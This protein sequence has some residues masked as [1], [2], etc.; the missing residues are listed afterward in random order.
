MIATPRVLRKRI[1]VPEDLGRAAGAI[2][3]YVQGGQAAEAGLAGYYSPDQALGQARG[4]LAEL[5]GL[6]GQVS[7]EALGRLLQ[8]RH[9]VT[10][11]PLLTGP[12]PAARAR[13]AGLV[14]NKSE[15]SSD[16]PGRESAAGS[17]HGD[18]LLTL[19]EAAAVAGVSVSHLRSLVSRGSEADAAPDRSDRTGGTAARQTPFRA[20]HERPADDSDPWTSEMHEEA[21]GEARSPGNDQPSGIRGADGRWRVRRDVLER[22]CAARVPRATVLGYDVVCAA[23]KSVSLLW[24]FGDEALRADVAAA[25]NAA[26]DATIGYLERHAAFGMVGGRNQRAF[27]LA[28]ASYLHDVS[29]A[30]EAHLHVHNIVINALAVPS[31][32]AGP[33]GERQGPNAGRVV[34]GWD[35]RAVDGE[36]LLAHVRT[37]G[38]VGAAVLRHELSARRGLQ[39]GPVRNGVAELADFP[40]DLLAAFSTRH[41]EVEEEFAQLVAGGLE[42]SGAT[43]SVA[44]RE[45]R[46]PKRVVADAAVRALQ[47]E[48]L[49]AAGWS[50][51]EVRALA[52]PGFH[53]P[54]PV[55]DADVAGLFDL[56]AGPTGMTEKT[57]A[58]VRRD[59]VRRVSEWGGDRLDAAAVE[60]LTDRFLADPRVVVLV[61]AAPGQRRR[62][63]PEPIYTV[64]GLLAAEERLSGLVRAGQVAFGAA[65]RRLVDRRTLTAHLAAVG[66]TAARG[67]GRG[68]ASV[69]GAPVRA[70]TPGFQGA[71]AHGDAEP[72]LS[73][74]QVALVRRLLVG[75]DL[76]R[77]AVG[78]AGTGKTE[79]MRLLTRIVRATGRQIFATAHGGRQAEELAERIGI[80]AR[81]VASWLEKLAHVDDPATVWPPGSVLIVDEATQVGTRDAERLLHFASRTGTVVILLGDPAQLGSVAA[82]G[83]FAH[84]V[85]QTADVPTLTTVRRQ[86]GA[87]LTAVR[88]A[89][90]ALRADT[91]AGT[92]VALERLAADGKIRLVDDP[93]ALLAQAVADW[94]TERRQHSRAVRAD[95]GAAGNANSADLAAAASR[96]GAVGA[97][98]GGATPMPGHGAPRSGRRG[99]ASGPAA[100][101]MMAE[102]H[103]D[104]EMLNQAARALLAADGTLTGPVLTVAGRDFQAADEVVTLTQ[105][106]HTLVPDGRPGS[107]YIR[108][109]TTGTVTA[110][111]NDPDHPAA[112]SV[113]VYFPSKGTV[114]VPWEYLTHQFA[115]GRDGGLAHA[116][117]LTAAKAQGA[118]MDTARAI[119]PD[120]TSRA[121]L[122][123]MLSRARSDVA[124]YV[125][126]RDDLD[127]RDDDET[128]LPAEPSATGDPLDRLADRLDRSEQ[129]RPAGARD[130][131]AAAAHQLSRHHAL[132]ELTALRL[133]ALPGHGQDGPESAATGMGEVSGASGARNAPS[134]T[135]P[136]AP[137]AP[138]APMRAAP[139]P[140]SA[141]DAPT[142][143]GPATAAGPAD[144]PRQVLLRRAELGAEAALR[145]AAL[146]D[147]PA[148][149]VARIGPR[150]EAGPDQAVWDDAVAALTIY[151]ARH[152]PTAPAHLAGPPPGS[153]AD[154][155]ARD[156]WLRHRAQATRLADDWAAALPAAIRARFAGPGQAVP[157][158]RAIAGLHALL[159]AGHPPT[160]LADALRA[161]SLDGIRAGA[162]VLERRVSDLC[163]Q[164]GIDPSLYDLPAP[165]T[166]QEEWNE[167]T[168][169]L[170]L[171]ETN[172]LATRPTMDLTAERHTL[173]HALAA[174]VSVP[175]TITSDGVAVFAPDSPA[176]ERFE[177]TA[178]LARLDA[179]LDRQAVDAMARAKTEPA[180]YL[181]AL[182]G[183][184]P[185]GPD[186]E[187]W[188]Q[189]ASR[190]E[191]YRHRLA[192]LPYGAPAAPHA[193]D[194]ARYAL[195][196]RPA[197]ST[198]A[199]DYDEACDVASLRDGQLTI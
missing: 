109:G 104:V 92:R 57:T 23:P 116:Y 101:R 87:D 39:W 34:T 170:A 157:R 74:E 122:Y 24:A 29:R 107:A 61:D 115:D 198:A 67:P 181:T 15:A 144:V 69:E 184:R 42:P 16:S 158:A 177:Q 153:H 51:D 80:P 113:T 146:A 128:W 38:F 130:P 8:G 189:A 129:E 12:D 135:K 188:D 73:G 191:R 175:V 60:R 110:V 194:P 26:V 6:R 21:E 163:Q 43:K 55:G 41:R 65:P 168:D 97:N 120:D 179:A 111:H 49:T 159:D 165:R 19:V 132:A 102:R 166:A 3:A 131:I 136:T 22:W 32:P 123:V 17:G 105:T 70:A 180:R 114:Q 197:D 63:E 72:L 4:R 44:Q 66:A 138:F 118:T 173:T 1:R 186:A 84:L 155:Q 99:R 106:G 48:K 78:A 86:A 93:D 5:V 54:Q 7:G 46:A 59:V 71:D 193:A 187:T 126:R 140:R 139:D 10:N 79:A 13:H 127:A 50:V 33:G 141:P 28:V 145:S 30:V 169:L 83:W 196:D 156:P 98:A 108:T 150:L 81:V 14:V 11:R 37:A 117:A 121:G 190:V 36:V 56:L 68:R 162:P 142:P 154:D 171:A 147:P 45:S 40:V 31:D 134:S 53:R 182:L 89:L 64:E 160:A 119:V 161:D 137:V 47:V 124:A 20:D 164:T 82:G 18:D 151:R 100:A 176:P 77:L 9:A 94:Y 152:Q 172:H 195:G 133:G 178:R 167:V 192:G 174:A 185:T 76:V 95:R 62:Q 52:R 103:R 25:L 27:G 183:P 149:L 148:G 199:A 2:V 75:E 35:W 143:E 112:Q 58:F 125:L 88:A 91:A 90:G 85:A 96:S